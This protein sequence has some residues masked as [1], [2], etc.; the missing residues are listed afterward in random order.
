MKISDDRGKISD[1]VDKRHI[2][3]ISDSTDRYFFPWLEQVR[4]PLED[5]AGRSENHSPSATDRAYI[6]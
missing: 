1:P 5:V 3:E 6:I 4:L 2:S